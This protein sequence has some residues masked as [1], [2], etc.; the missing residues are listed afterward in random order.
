MAPGVSRVGSWLIADDADAVGPSAAFADAF[1]ASGGTRR[2]VVHDPGRVLAG[3]A[4][5]LADGGEAIGE[6]AVLRDRS[7]VDVA[8]ASVPTAWRVL[9]SIDE[10]LL[11]ELSQARVRCP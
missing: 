11:G 1:T 9:N 7:E 6:L 5:M 4:V 2:R 8:V 3:V 10:Q